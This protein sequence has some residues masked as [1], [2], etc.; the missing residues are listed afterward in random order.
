MA[1]RSRRQKVT[2][3]NQEVPMEDARRA[4]TA[5]R[6]P[7]IDMVLCAVLAAA[8]SDPVAGT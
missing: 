1:R 6:R 3:A 4:V 8:A 5:I 7:T 2:N